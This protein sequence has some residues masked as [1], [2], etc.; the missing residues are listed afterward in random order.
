MSDVLRWGILGS[1]GIARKNWEA[2]K[3]SGNGIVSA[4]ASRDVTKA[5]RFIEECQAEVPFAEVPRAIGGYEEILRA[6]DVDAVYIPLPTGLRE[7]W[8]IKAAE[9]GKHVMC[10]KPC[11]VNSGA[12]EAM[13]EACAAN[14]VQ[15]MDGVM[16]MHSARMPMLREALNDPANIGAIKRISS[17][18]TFCAP[19]EFFGDNI[20]ASSALEPAGALGDLGWYTIRA[21]LF[22]MNYEMPTSLRAT[23]LSTT[24]REDSP[25]PVPSELSAELFFAKGVSATFYNS[26]LTGN[27]QWFHV[28][29]TKGH[30]RIDDFALP[31][32]GEDLGFV[33]SNPEFTQDGCKFAMR[34][35]Q[36]EFSVEEKG[37]ND[38]NAQESKLFRT[39]AKLALGGTPDP[40]WPEI[41]LKTQRVLD[42]C[43]HSAQNGG[44]TV[45]L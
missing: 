4:V 17:A 41:S 44:V 7:E 9:S 14:N 27:Q 26:F 20:R 28:G 32:S 11:A 35:H 42:A 33:V 30:L 24:S 31:F 8:V 13:T 37:N 22:V 38:P 16:F 25:N 39:F 34:N 2:I 45:E 23:M 40:F 1:A 15:F 18:F 21:T 19:P 10:E 12:L 36:S 29:G 6:D 43:L 5:Q 3:N